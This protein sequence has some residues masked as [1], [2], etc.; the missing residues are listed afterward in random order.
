MAFTMEED[1]PPSKKR[2]LSLSLKRK[3][4]DD[5]SDRFKMVTDCEV[6]EAAKGVV[7]SN[8]KKTN[9]WAIQNFDQ[10]ATV[11]S[12]KF[13]DDPVPSDILSCNDP[14]LLCKWLSRYVM[15]TRQQTGKPYPPSTIYSVWSLSCMSIKW[16]SF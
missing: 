15:E 1:Q 2:R 3:K 16:C 13:P 14:D 8:T 12:S 7:P 10:W 4:T 6:Q 9:Q 11:R 5:T